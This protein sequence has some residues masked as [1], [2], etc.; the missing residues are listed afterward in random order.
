MPLRSTL[1][2]AVLTA[3]LSALP[4][5]AARDPGQSTDGDSGRRDGVDGPDAGRLAPVCPGSPIDSRVRVEVGVGC[6]IR[7]NVSL[8]AVGDARV[9]R[10]QQYLDGYRTRPH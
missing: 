6:D 9:L 1:L 8:S 2:T 7:L 10:D 5:Q 3:G 4:L